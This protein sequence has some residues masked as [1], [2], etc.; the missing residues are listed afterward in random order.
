[1]LRMSNGFFHT[2]K[3]VKTLE[4][5]FYVMLLLFAA[6]LTAGYV[7]TQYYPEEAAASLEHMKGIFEWIKTLNPLVITLI[8]FA[9]NVLKS[10]IALLLGLGFGI[11]PLLF[12]ISNGFIIGILVALA[13]STRGLLFVAAALLPHGV[14]EVPMILLSA[15]IGLRLGHAVF[16][17]LRKEK[18]DIIYEFKR[19][20]VFY[21]RWI[22]PLLL[23]S[24]VVESFITPI[25]ISVVL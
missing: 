14:I 9:N 8:I 17:T 23:L 16:S 2:S 13:G 12:V 1:M 5:Y 4:G 21:L 19:G 22:M 18:V 24:A 15:A 25:F 20:V 3:Y 10:L 7:Y 11:I 6:S